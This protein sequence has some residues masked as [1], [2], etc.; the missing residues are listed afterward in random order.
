LKEEIAKHKAKIQQLTKAGK[1][2]V[3]NTAKA[4]AAA[5][6]RVASLEIEL[7]KTR[8]DERAASLVQAEKEL[9]KKMAQEL[10]DLKAQLRS[11]SKEKKK[12]KG[13]AWDEDSDSDSS[14]QHAAATRKRLRKTEKTEQQDSQ[15]MIEQSIQRQLAVALEKM[16]P[17]Q[18]TS[19]G[20]ATTPFSMGGPVGF[21]GYTNPLMYPQGPGLAPGQPIMSS[22]HTPGH[23][24]MPGWVPS[25]IGG[26]HV[27]LQD[28]G[29]QAPQASARPPAPEPRPETTSTLAP[30]FGAGG[31][32]QPVS[33]PAPTTANDQQELMKTL[34]EFLKQ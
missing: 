3:K 25:N 21:Q 28:P 24:A 27:H 22:W 7:E 11:S 31:Q 19:T 10:E 4:A 6:A 12:P 2:E 23:P 14:G 5:N 33:A 20:P 17:Q 15:Q 1:D 18:T 13:R 30:S 32:P 8:Q 29:H 16:L 26:T 34:W 9:N